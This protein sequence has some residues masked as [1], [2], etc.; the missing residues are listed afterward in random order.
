MPKL[1]FHEPR[2]TVTDRETIVTIDVDRNGR[3]WARLWTFE[4][5]GETHPWHACVGPGMSKYRASYAGLDAIK[6][7]VRSIEPSPPTPPRRPYFGGNTM[8]PAFTDPRVAYVREYLDGWIA[9]S[10]RWPAPGTMTIHERDGT[11]TSAKYD[12]KRSGGGGPNWVAFSAKHG[13]LAS[14]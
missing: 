2:R 5:D 7:W 1:K 9:N 11:S 4:A 8:H 3:P 14:G 12:R 6:D 10:Y 13:R